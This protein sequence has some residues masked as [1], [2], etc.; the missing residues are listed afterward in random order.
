ML[1][2]IGNYR[3]TSETCIYLHKQCSGLVRV[4]RE[5]RQSARVRSHALDFV[6]KLKQL[7]Y[8]FLMLGVLR[9]K[10]G[11]MRIVPKSRILMNNR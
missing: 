6:K 3:D 5:S 2:F 11:I 10:P 4:H 7:L 9:H 8:L 1:H